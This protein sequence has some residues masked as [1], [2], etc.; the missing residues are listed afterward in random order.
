MAAKLNATSGIEKGIVYQDNSIEQDLSQNCFI[1]TTL[2]RNQYQ[3][4]L[5][6]LPSRYDGYL[7]G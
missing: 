7:V 2:Q 6:F 1:Q 5:V 4:S 3:P